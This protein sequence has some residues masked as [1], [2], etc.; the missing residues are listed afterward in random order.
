MRVKT[1]AV[2]RSAPI[3][4]KV[5]IVLFII[6]ATAAGYY[7]WHRS[8]NLPS[9]SVAYVLPESLGVVD[10]P[11]E[12]RLGVTTLKQGDRVEV[13]DRSRNWTKIRLDDGR[14]GWVE[15]LNLIDGDAYEAARRLF[16]DL[17]RELPQA[18]GHVINEANLR[19]D[20][21]RDAPP[22]VQLPANQRVEIFGRRLVAR[23][24]Q[25]GAPT[26]AEP[27]RDAWY[28]VRAESK[29]GWVLGRLV[30]LD[31]PEAIS[32]YAQDVNLV[33]WV[34]LNT[35]EDN[36][37]QIPQY[38]AADR[39]TATDCDFTRIRIFTWWVKRQQYVTA[40]VESNLTGYFPIRVSEID[41]ISYF[42]LRLENA[43]GRKFQRVYRMFDTIARPLGTVDGWDSQAMPAP[44]APDSRIPA[45]TRRP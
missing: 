18:S 41:G 27:A 17:Q 7:R 44:R 45:R 26:S 43:T 6:G 20:P 42:R 23:P 15:T 1:S 8:R 16:G 22:L 40:Y 29:A 38:I 2:L 19:V 14:T 31:V 12:I 33:A 9:V 21:A 34:V 39:Q 11:A 4:R 30:S 35:V 25:E 24:P 28:L 32:H 37:R 10:S 5:I 13:L 3:G 36:G